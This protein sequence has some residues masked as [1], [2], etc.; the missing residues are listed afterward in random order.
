MFQPYQHSLTLHF[1]AGPW[2]Q[3]IHDA[4]SSTH[5]RA[6][7]EY[8]H[9]ARLP[10][11]KFAPAAPAMASQ[12]PTSKQA[13]TRQKG[14]DA[15]SHIL[16]LF[17]PQ[18]VCENSLD[19]RRPRAPSVQL[20][21]TVDLPIAPKDGIASYERIEF[22][23]PS[24][25]CHGTSND[26]SN[27]TNNSTS[28]GTEGFCSQQHLHFSC[29]PNLK[30]NLNLRDPIGL[31][32]YERIDV[33]TGM[34]LF[35]PAIIHSSMS[36]DGQVDAAILERA[37]HT[38]YEID[39]ISRGTSALADFIAALLLTFQAEEIYI[40][41]HVSVDLPSSHYYGY[42][43]QYVQD[44]RCSIAEAIRWLGA[45]ERR[46]SQIAEV[47]EESL[48]HQLK[49]RGIGNES[50]TFSVSS[51]NNLLSVATYEALNAGHMPRLDTVWQRLKVEKNFDTAW[52]SFLAVL[53]EKEAPET[54]NDLSHLLH[55]FEVVRLP[56]EQGAT[57]ARTTDSAGAGASGGHLVLAIDVEA[58]RR[59]YKRA[60]PLFKK[61]GAKPAEPKAGKKGSVSVS[62]AGAELV[63][64][65]AYLMPP[66]APN[67]P[68]GT[69]G[70]VDDKDILVDEALV[71]A[72]ANVGL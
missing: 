4:E 5:K 45:V 35:S 17:E 70:E 71:A 43:A 63:L 8:Q 72:F 27:G 56:L 57:R 23:F 16:G 3:R 64:V 29:T 60:Q 39:F 40:P 61:L 15:A 10:R 62:G 44:E 59:I 69:G 49:L 55:I 19:G 48:R 14:R 37:N 54:F 34:C 33:F 38:P 12:A 7:S 65:E 53:P 18:S 42:I 50:F 1:L 21:D 36:E 58:Q 26:T 52:P 31:P 22:N 24:E 11:P 20:Q 47:F 9:R 25:D 30:A 68:E 66:Q 32:L 6:I 51:T 28:T 67:R 46:H 13:K 2:L 41:I